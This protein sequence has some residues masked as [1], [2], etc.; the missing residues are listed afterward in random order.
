MSGNWTLVN[1]LVGQW[2]VYFALV[3]AVVKLCPTIMALGEAER[4]VTLAV[5]TMHLGCLIQDV[6]TSIPLHS[7]NIWTCRCV[8]S[9]KLMALVTNVLMYAGVNPILVDSVTGRPNPMVRWAHYVVSTF[10]MVFIIE[11]HD[12][13]SYHSPV[14]KALGN[15]FSTFCGMCLPLLSSVVLWVIVFVLS[16]AFFMTL[17]WSV[18]KRA[19]KLKQRYALMEDSSFATQQ[20]EVSL[21]LSRGC[22]YLWSM[23]TVIFCI[24]VAAR[25]HL[26]IDFATDY[27]FIADSIM[28]LAAKLLYSSTIQ[29]HADAEPVFFDQQC[30]KL[31]YERLHTV[32]TE[33]GDVLIVRQAQSNLRHCNMNTSLDNCICS[34]HGVAAITALRRRSYDCRLTERSTPAK[35]RRS[36]QHLAGVCLGT[37]HSIPHPI[38]TLSRIPQPAAALILLPALCRVCACFGPV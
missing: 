6:M 1:L 3:I 18:W 14:L 29:E 2:V 32:W 23:Y 26:R 9:I 30:M 33:A 13:H 19:D 12:S 8:R 21:K 27:A 16:F 31:A 4:A 11:A 7:S 38:T 37:R 24:D 35:A 10:M 36:L 22:A 20:A 25:M 15:M 34:S 17:P 5:S 28:D